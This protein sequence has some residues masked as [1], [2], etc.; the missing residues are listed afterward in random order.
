MNRRATTR[1]VA[2]EAGVSLATVDRVLNGRTGVRAITVER[3]NAAIERLGYRKDLA[4]EALSRERFY[5][6]TFLIP[7]DGSSFVTALPDIIRTAANGPDAARTDVTIKAIT[8][9]DAPGLAREL[10]HLSPSE[11]DGVAVVG[12]DATIVR[13]AIDRTIARGIQVVTLISDVPGSGRGHYVG[14]DNVAAGRTAA[15]LLGRFIDSTGGTVQVILGSM[16]LRDHVERRFGFEQ[17][18]HTEFAHL[19]IAPVIEGFEDNDRTAA[20]LRA[21]FEAIPEINGLYII[22]G[23]KRGVTS[24]LRA[25]NHPSRVSVI[26]HEATPESRQALIDGHF[27][28]L[29][30]QDPGHEARSAIRVLKCL[31]DGTPIQSEQERIRIE[32]FLRD[33]LI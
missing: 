22:G 9:L 4:A 1:D 32:I 6:L 16:L 21:R 8:K 11:C 27:D 20:E 2:K 10:D 19:D 25:M 15:S 13:D 28:A 12:T 24:A 5:R 29:L 33:N 31:I 14:I 23:G 3:V 26:A 18:I 30:Q 7:G 17:V